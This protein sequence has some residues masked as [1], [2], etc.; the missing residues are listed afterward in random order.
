MTNTNKDNLANEFE[1]SV[2][3]FEKCEDCEIH[4]WTVMHDNG[5]ELCKE[6]YVK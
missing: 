3:C 5:K 1:L 2:Q 4:D 6:C